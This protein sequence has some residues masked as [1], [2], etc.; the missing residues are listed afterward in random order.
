MWCYF[1]MKKKSFGYKLEIFYYPNLNILFCFAFN[2]RNVTYSKFFCGLPWTLDIY[3]VIEFFSIISYFLSNFICFLNNFICWAINL[4]YSTSYR[5]ISKINFWLD[6]D[7]NEKYSQ[8]LEE[9]KWEHFTPNCNRWANYIES[10]L[11]SVLG[12]QVE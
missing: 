10:P 8:V 9:L 7:L 3:Q 1:Q 2:F 4:L 5:E 11:L 12:Y 6:R